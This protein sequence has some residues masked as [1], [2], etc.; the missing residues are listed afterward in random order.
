ML[1]FTIGD[2]TKIGQVASLCRLRGGRY[3][4]MKPWGGSYQICASTCTSGGRCQSDRRSSQWRWTTRRHSTFIIMSWRHPSPCETWTT[5][6]IGDRRCHPGYCYIKVRGVIYMTAWRCYEN[7]KLILLPRYL[8]YD[9]SQGR[10]LSTRYCKCIQQ[11]LSN[12]SGIA[13]LNSEGRL[14]STEL[15]KRKRMKVVVA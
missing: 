6:M 10:K 1:I 13:N 11:E 5:G 12:H 8:W 15:S 7:G 4:L 9:N 14:Y 3:P 2:K